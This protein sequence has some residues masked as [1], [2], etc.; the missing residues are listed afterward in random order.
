MEFTKFMKRMVELME[1]KGLSDKTI[2]YYLDRAY[3]LNNKKKF[4]S[5]KF[6]RDTNI[7][8]PLLKENLSTATQK[9]YS[10]TL[11]TLLDLYPNKL[12]KKAIDIYKNFISK[13][14]MDQY[15]QEQDKKT[16]KQADNWLNLDELLEIKNKLNEQI[17]QINFEKKLNQKEYLTI[18]K[19][20]ILSLYLNLAPRRSSD[21]TLMKIGPDEDESYNYLNLDKKELIFNQY[22]TKK[23]YGKQIIDISN[24]KELLEDLNLYLKYR[25]SDNDFLLIKSNGKPFNQTNDM[26]KTLNQIFGKKI[27]TQMLRNIYLTSKYGSVKTDLKQDVSEMGTS[28]KCALNIYSKDCK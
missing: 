5:I 1:A 26:T 28:M 3:R 9:S 16:E 12:N 18:L 2:Q 14:D 6:L 24:N 13:E 19:N 20:F 25:K 10:G 7:I 23:T 8:I 17:K 22:K 11:I 15:I 21:Y 4:T 27:S